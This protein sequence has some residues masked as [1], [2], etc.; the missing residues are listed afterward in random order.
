[1]KKYLLLLCLLGCSLVT[2]AQQTVSGVANTYAPVSAIASGNVITIG[3][4]SGAAHSWA[5]GDYVLVAQM[6]GNTDVFAGHYDYAKVTAVSG[7][8][9]T[10]TPLS[11]NTTLSTRYDPTGEKVQLVWVPYSATGFIVTSTL[12]PL[13][14]NGNVGGI[15]S[16]LTP[17]SVS[18]GGNI[19]A[20]C[21]GFRPSDTNLLTGNNIYYAG[22][23]GGT[24]T[25]GGASGGSYGAI[26]YTSG[27]DNYIPA[28]PS[29]YK[30]GTPGLMSGN[31]ESTK[32]GAGGG[33]GVGAAGGGGGGGWNGGGGG[34]GASPSKG[35]CGGQGNK[36]PGGVG[37]IA[38]VGGTSGTDGGSVAYQAS[39]GGGGGTYAGGGGGGSGTFGSAGVSNGGQAG[40]LGGAGGSTGQYGSGGGGAGGNGV[41]TYS[42]YALLAPGGA[43][44]TRPQSGYINFLNTTNP[45]ILMGA[46]S[47][48]SSVGG[49]IVLIQASTLNSNGYTITADG[50]NGAQAQP[51]NIQYADGGAGGGNIILDVMNVNTA[52]SVSAKGGNGG[53]G[54]DITGNYMNGGAGGGGGGAI[55]VYSASSSNNINSTATAPTV[56]NVTF[57]IAGGTGG[58]AHDIASFK[59]PNFGAD[60]GCGGAGI[61]Y[62]SPFSL[63]PF[64]S[65]PSY[66]ATA[67]AATCTGST[68]NSNGTI[69]LTG[70]ATGARYQYSLGSTFGTGIP[71]TIAAV[72]S[73]GVITNTLANPATAQVYTVRVYDPADDTCFTDKQVTLN[74]TTCSVP[75]TSPNCITTINVVIK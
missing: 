10:V 58:I 27:W 67:T 19:D 16:L 60:G 51:T 63:V 50:C 35:G 45:R 44:Y 11:G 69:T 46:P 12:T 75:C 53:N 40:E 5:V 2:L 14:W 20:S 62:A 42:T 30:G 55:W 37:S 59:Q 17:G 65:P 31:G 38:G 36:A 29:T 70:F 18:L 7:S 22:G 39:G 32:G 25:G 43:A 73:G 4:N 23:P 21:K 57:N 34:G 1:M 64:C 74:P 54:V 15:V 24:Y 61:V 41:E 71:A 26:G 49:G 33:A 6:T 56:P 3:A 13:A 47:S 52:L 66:T 8:N 9:I 72:P 48:L 28:I 68:A